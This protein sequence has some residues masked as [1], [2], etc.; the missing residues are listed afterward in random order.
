MVERQLA[1]TVGRMKKCRVFSPHLWAAFD[2]CRCMVLIT[3]TSRYGNCE[4]FK[5]ESKSPER[6]T[7]AISRVQSSQQPSDQK[8][9]FLQGEPKDKINRFP[10]PK[11]GTP[12]ETR[13]SGSGSRWEGWNVQGEAG[14]S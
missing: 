14:T 13:G 4:N 8:L 10:D 11:T 1:K 7:S 6:K 12:R 9:I 3:L 2:V 5:K